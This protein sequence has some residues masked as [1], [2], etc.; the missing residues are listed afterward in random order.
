MMRAPGMRG[1]RSEGP[2]AGE[3]GWQDQSLVGGILDL[4]CL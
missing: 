1:R 4:Q 2:E 3:L